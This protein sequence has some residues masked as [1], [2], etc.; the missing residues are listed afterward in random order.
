MQIRGSTRL[1][2]KRAAAG[3]RAPPKTK[4]ETKKHRPARLALARAKAD[5]RELFEHAPL[6]YFFLAAVVQDGV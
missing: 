6:L 1:P 3:W 2:C 4:T 5:S